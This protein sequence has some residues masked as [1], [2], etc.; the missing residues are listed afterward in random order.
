[1][2]SVKLSVTVRSNLARKYDAVGLT[3]IDAAVKRWIAADK[4]RWIDTIHVAVDD[5]VA[6]KALGTKPIEGRATAQKVK[7]AIDAL[8]PRV[9]PEYL[10]LF[11]AYD[12]VPYFVVANPSYD[13]SGDTDATVRTDNP[14]ACSQPYRTSS[15]N[16]YLVPDRV[17]GRIADAPG[18]SDPI[19][20]LDYLATA[21]D[22]ASQPRKTYTGAY[23]I[24]CDEW[25]GAG[26]ECVQVIGEPVTRLM[27]S[28]PEDDTSA[29]AQSRLGARL[30]MIKC[31]GAQLD[32]NFYGQKGNSFPVSLS[33]A[34][35]RKKVSQGTVAGAMC[36]YGAQVFSPVDEAVRPVGAWPIASTYLRG[37]GY[38]FAGST[39]IAWVGGPQKACADWIVTGYLKS[40][41]GGASQGRALLESKQDFMRWLAQQGSALGRDDE[42]TLIE[43]VLLGD[44]AIQPVGVQPAVRAGVGAPRAAAGEA[45]AAM[46]SA[47]AVQER[48]QRRLFQAQ[49]AAQIREAL[50]SRRDARGAVRA[51][52]NQLFG[53]VDD[54]LGGEAEAFQLSKAKV[55]VDRLETV[56][57]RAQTVSAGFRAGLTGSARRVALPA[58]RETFQFYWSG[59]R[60]VEGHLQIRLARVETDAQGRVLRTRVVQSS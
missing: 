17:V 52:A 37:G 41:L 50:P 55:R 7:R 59:S 45:M 9:S 44:P 19:W 2:Q 39:E 22:W 54:L 28:P 46:P 33:S 18:E 60:V 57:S 21:T 56:F 47:V 25:S 6:M 12:V 32:P 15:I 35:L 29:L 30:H 38:G 11:G 51:R 5:A 24:C 1:M 40:I 3:K 27:I 14:Y 20:F 26:V 4:K 10:V 13:S 8:W 16:T 42:K 58:R 53:L 48:V 31:H 49:L 23:A 43:Y 36:C 34:S